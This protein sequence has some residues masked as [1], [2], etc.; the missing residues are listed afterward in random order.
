MLEKEDK[1]VE[2]WQQVYVAAEYLILDLEPSY[3]TVTTSCECTLLC[4]IIPII[5]VSQMV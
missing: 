2:L 4:Q 3:Q 5:N 1:L